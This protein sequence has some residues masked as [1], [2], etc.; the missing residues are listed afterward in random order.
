M[1]DHIIRHTYAS[2]ISQMSSKV[3]MSTT[4]ESLYLPGGL[5]AYRDEYIQRLRDYHQKGIV[6]VGRTTWTLPLVLRFTA[7]HTWEMQDK[8]LNI[9]EERTH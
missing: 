5:K 2:E 7:Y 6:K 8:D 4:L 9:N 1:R 3:G